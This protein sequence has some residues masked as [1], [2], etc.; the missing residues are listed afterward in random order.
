M[1]LA[2]NVHSNS[3]QVVVTTSTMFSEMPSEEAGRKVLD[4]NPVHFLFSLPQLPFHTFPYT[5]V[6]I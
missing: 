4:A 2:V 5:T 3:E 1:P 6:I